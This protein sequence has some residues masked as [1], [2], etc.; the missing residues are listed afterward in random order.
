MFVSLLPTQSA[1]ITP[2]HALE[3]LASPKTNLKIAINTIDKNQNALQT[4]KPPCLYLFTHA[5]LFLFSIAPSI[6]SG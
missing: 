5:S 4:P 3:I 6:H 2:L 1:N